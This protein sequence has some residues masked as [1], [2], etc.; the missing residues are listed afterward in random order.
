VD[1]PEFGQQGQASSDLE[2][3][4][5]QW[6][7]ILHFSQFAGYIVP[8]AGMIVPI[9]LWQLKKDELPGIDEHGRAVVN[10]IISEIIYILIGIALVF[11]VIGIPLLFGLALIGIIFPLIGGIKANEGVLWKYPLPMSFL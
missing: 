9:V 6:A 10:W 7:M 3:Q 2:R 8:L 4:S 11:V 1:D 5:R